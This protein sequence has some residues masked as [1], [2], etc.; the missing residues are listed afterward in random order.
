MQRLVSP[1]LNCVAS[2]AALGRSGGP[3]RSTRTGK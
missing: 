2:A 1:H 3:R